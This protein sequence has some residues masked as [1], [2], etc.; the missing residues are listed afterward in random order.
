MKRAVT[1]II[2]TFI[3]LFIREIKQDSCSVGGELIN[4]Q[5]FANIIR[6]G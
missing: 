3:T 4:E 6:E 2:S 1:L 5:I